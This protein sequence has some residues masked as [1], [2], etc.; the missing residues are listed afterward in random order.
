MVLI[1]HQLAQN[2]RLLGLTSGSRSVGILRMRVVVGG[3]VFLALFVGI[4][5]VALFL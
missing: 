1:A 3:V 5:P 2:I 4:V